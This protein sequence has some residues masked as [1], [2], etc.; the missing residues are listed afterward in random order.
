[1]TQKEQGSTNYIDKEEFTKEMDIH[2]MECRAAIESGKPTPKCPES[3][4]IKFLLIATNVANKG[5]FYK[6]TYKDEMVSD[7]V[8]NMVRYRHNYK[9][10]RG[11]AFSYFTTYA[12]YAFLARIK[13]EKKEQHKRIKLMQKLAVHEMAPHVL[14][15]HD[16]DME[17][18]NEY[19]E[20]L[21]QF[22][23]ER[24]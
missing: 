16:L 11:H 7:A 9:K 15:D 18:R 17:F 5:N 13:T 3:I 20:W 1:M 24:G 22:A 2:A 19:A 12:I 21:V 14:N 8:E 4:G 10:E 23:D 6:Y